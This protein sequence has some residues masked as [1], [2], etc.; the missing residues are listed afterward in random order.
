MKIPHEFIRNTYST[1]EPAEDSPMLPELHE[2]YRVPLDYVMIPVQ[3]YRQLIYGFS[4][5]ER[6]I[7]ELTDRAIREAMAKEEALDFINSESSRHYLF[8]RYRE[9]KARRENSGDPSSHECAH[10]AAE[11]D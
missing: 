11:A 4:S 2:S 5:K 7:I 9:D 3:E 10:A 8:Q 6:Q 1:A